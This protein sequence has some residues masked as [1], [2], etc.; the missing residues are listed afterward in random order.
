MLDRLSDKVVEVQV[1]CVIHIYQIYLQKYWTKMIVVGRVHF[2][3]LKC[4]HM[5]K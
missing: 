5:A 1:S 4:K 2:S 3:F